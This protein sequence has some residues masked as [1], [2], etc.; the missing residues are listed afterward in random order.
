MNFYK[1]VAPAGA[2]TLACLPRLG[3]GTLKDNFYT[4]KYNGSKDCLADLIFNRIVVASSHRM[5]TRYMIA[6]S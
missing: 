4:S 2:K 5:P 1:H 3:L 6:D